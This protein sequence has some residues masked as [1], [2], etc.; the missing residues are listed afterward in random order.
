M[1]DA[2][3]EAVLVKRRTKSL[4]SKASKKQ[5]PALTIV[6]G[7]NSNR[8]QLPLGNP[9]HVSKTPPCRDLSGTG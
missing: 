6:I 2:N 1:T 4:R 9:L 8:A 7:E 3:V 5:K